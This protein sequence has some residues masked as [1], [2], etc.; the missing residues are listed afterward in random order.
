MIYY[1]YDILWL[2][3]TM[4]IAMILIADIADIADML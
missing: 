4:A 3:Y 2:W 1:G